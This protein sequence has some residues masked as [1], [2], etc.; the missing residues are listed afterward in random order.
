MHTCALCIVIMHI[1]HCSNS[2]IDWYLVHYYNGAI[3]WCKVPY[4]N[5][6]K[7]VIRLDSCKSYANGHLFHLLFFMTCLYSQLAYCLLQL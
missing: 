5:G 4:Y 6:A 2:A 1:V 7:E 3:D